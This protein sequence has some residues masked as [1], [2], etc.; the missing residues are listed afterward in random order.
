MTKLRLP[1]DPPRSEITASMLRVNHAGEYG[2][3]RIYQGQLGV[4][5]KDPQAK[6]IKHMQKQEQVHLDFFV[7]ELQ[8]RNIRPS[9]FHPLWHVGGW[10]LGFFSA[11]LG[12]KHAFACTV[13]VEDVISEHYKNQIEEIEEPDLAASI[14]K[15]RDEEIS[16]QEL[17]IEQQATSAVGYGSFTKAIKLLCKGAISIAKRY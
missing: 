5:K 16:H 12:K 11:L 10:A 3:L 14:A 8:N 15:F 6:V 1:G 7:Q 17:S 9:I 2:A 4:L 13:A